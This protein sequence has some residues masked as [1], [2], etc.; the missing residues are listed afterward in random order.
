MNSLDQ[1][2]I[3]EIAAGETLNIEF[4]SDDKSGGLSDTKVVEAAAA[5]SNAQGGKIYIGVRDSGEIIGSERLRTNYWKN[6]NALEGVIYAGTTPSLSCKVYFY[7]HGDNQIVCINV[8]KSETTIGTK[9]GHFLRRRYNSK[10]HPENGPM[11][12]DE[13][14]AGV[15]RIG[16][17]DFS[18]TILHG[19]SID[20]ID[21]NLV[22]QMASQLVGTS[23]DE[24]DK[25]LFSQSPTDLLK[26]LGLINKDMQPNVACLLVFGKEEAIRDRL[27]NNYIQYQVF[28]EEGQLYKNLRFEK[29]IASLFKELIF[30]PELLRNSDEFRLKGQTFVIPEYPEDSRRE[31][32]ANAIVHRDY[33]LPAGIQIQLYENEL[34]VINPGGFPPGIEERN[35]LSSPPTPRNRRLAEVMSKLK[36]V[37]SSGRGIDFIYKGQAIY[38]RPAPDYS[39][40]ENSRVSVRL[41]GGKAN[42]DFC[43]FIFSTVNNPSITEV[44]ILN[45]LFLNRDQTLDELQKTIQKPATVTQQILYH[46]HQKGYIEI[47]GDRTI[48]YF[49]KGSLHPAVRKVV[50]PERMTEKQIESAKQQTIKELKRKSPLSKEELADLLGLSPSQT[51]RVLNK[52]KDE[53][54]ISMKNKLWVLG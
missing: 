5:M 38:G 29:P 11:N 27:P 21:L 26:S 52:L 8:P 30:L 16:T 39:A 43:K 10:G 24:K 23:S 7:E 19:S 25:A 35:L 15:T 47:S 9:S 12:A 22:Q 18:T 44:L 17:Q 28:G 42:L 34:I 2:I 31:A 37:E 32:F 4:K 54:K 41:V 48:K 50:K 13:I 49:L 46:I 40:S 20:E 6:E 51:Y 14:I 3:D 36:F 33:T 1:S 53:N 45:S